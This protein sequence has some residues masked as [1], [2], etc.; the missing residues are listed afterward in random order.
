M[1]WTTEIH[2]SLPD[3]CKRFFPF[4]KASRLK[5]H[6]EAQVVAEKE[7]IT[8]KMMRERERTRMKL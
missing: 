2:G 4:T 1:R 3:K 8:Y 7:V 6:H 5:L